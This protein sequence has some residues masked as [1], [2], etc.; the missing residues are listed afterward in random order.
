MKLSENRTECPIFG[1]SIG[2]PY[3]AQ[4]LLLMPGTKSH[5]GARH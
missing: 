5:F 4:N 2:H 3:L 1:Q